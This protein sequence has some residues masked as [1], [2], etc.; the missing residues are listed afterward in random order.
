MPGLASVFAAVADISLSGAVI[1][2]IEIALRVQHLPV[3][4]ADLIAPPR[5]HGKLHVARD[6]LSEVDHR[7]P[8]RGMQ[9]GPGGHALRLPDDLALLGDQ[10]LLRP[11]QQ[12]GS[13]PIL[14][15]KGRVITLA[16]ID[17]AETDRALG[18]LPAPVRTENM[19]AAI[20]IADA[21]PRDQAAGLIVAAL[22]VL[23][24]HKARHGRAEPTAPDR[25]TQLVFV[26]EQLRHIIGLHLQAVVVAG[27]ARGQHEVTYT[28]SVQLRL[29]DAKSRDFQGGGGHFFFRTK[30]LA[31]NRAHV[32]QLPRCGDPLTA[33]QFH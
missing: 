24:I 2:V 19:L 29:I 10:D 5:G 12:T 17:L 28:P 7:L 21:K 30:A 13:L 9:H 15:S 33:F 8:G 22:L 16:V 23:R 27:P 25:D 11:V 20:G 18:K 1:G 3:G 32:A 4:K 14:G 31:E 6:L 26:P